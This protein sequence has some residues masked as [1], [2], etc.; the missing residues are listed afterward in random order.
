[1]A[2]LDACKQTGKECNERVRPLLSRGLHSPYTDPLK[3]Y[4]EKETAHTHAGGDQQRGHD[5]NL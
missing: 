1:M 4:S 2:L 3:H 5:C